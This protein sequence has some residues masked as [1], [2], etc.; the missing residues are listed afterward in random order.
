MPSSNSAPYT[1]PQEIK[2]LFIDAGC[3]RAILENASKTY[4]NDNPIE[5]DY[6]KLKGRFTKVF[7]YDCLKPQQ[8]DE[9]NEDYESRIDPQRHLFN[10][11][12]LLD[13]YHVYEG[14][15]RR[16]R[17]VIEQKQVDVMIAVDMLTH[18]FMRNMHQATLFANDLDFKP[19]IDALVQNGMYIELWHQPGY[20]NEELVFSADSQKPIT[21]QTIYKWS[22]QKFKARYKIPTIRDNQNK[23]NG[24]VK[25]RDLYN[26][27]GTP[28]ELFERIGT[29]VDRDE[30][31]YHITFPEQESPHNKLVSFND[32]KLLTIFVKEVFPELEL[33]LP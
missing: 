4:F 30:D 15:T 7:Y 8:A 20:T 21:I 32:E 11:I 24:F 1:G 16:R 19:L 2:Y 29:F 6:Y 26:R 23:P 31:Q 12:R 10:Q 18:T 22:T 27:S 5:L 3:L 33:E 13:G 14:V 25:V 28:V 9:S 17:R